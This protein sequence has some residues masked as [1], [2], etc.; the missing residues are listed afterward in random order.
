ML[1]W[2]NAN[3]GAVLALVGSLTFV[4]I[5]A[6]SLA[7]MRMV[8]RTG[9]LIAHE[10]AERQGAHLAAVAAIVYELQG[11][12][13]SLAL[14][15]R[16]GWLMEE[17]PG[18]PNAYAQLLLDFHRGLPDDLGRRVARTYNVMARL[19]ANMAAH[20]APTARQMDLAYN[21]ELVPTVDAL[22]QYGRNQGRDV[23]NPIM[24][25]AREEIVLYDLQ[26]PGIL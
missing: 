22:C 13:Y 25:I 16:N 1:S 8:R 18:S 3:S 14:M 5:T 6:G 26:P 11:L 19:R 4:A 15:L 7:S 20:M 9:Q 17:L 2:L 10:Q 24:P 12:A 21:D 23:A